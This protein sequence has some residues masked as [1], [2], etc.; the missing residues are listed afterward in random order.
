MKHSILPE[1]E[2]LRRAMRWL[3]DNRLTRTNVSPLQ[4]V[5]EAAVRF[6]LSPLE[7]DWMLRTLASPSEDVDD[8]GDRLR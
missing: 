4:L 1:G 2:H 3:S 5:G 6:D 8:S 7:E